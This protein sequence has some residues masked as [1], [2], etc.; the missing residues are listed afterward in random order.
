MLVVTALFFACKSKLHQENFVSK[1]L[2]VNNL[3]E[4]SFSINTKK[5]TT[6][7][8]QQGIVI[9]IDAGS[10]EAAIPN[11]TLQVKEALQL[12]DI[13]KAGL[14]TQTK[15]GILSSDGMFHIQTKE[16]SKIIKPLQIQLPTEVVD[17]NM[18]LYKGAEEDGKIV[19][20]EPKKLEPK[21][22]DEPDGKALFVK[23][24][25]SCHAIDKKLTGPALGGVETRWNKKIDL[26]NYI[27]NTSK[28]MKLIR[29]SSFPAT[30]TIP[31]AV[32][33]IKYYHNVEGNTYT[34]YDSAYQMDWGYAN[35]MYC[36]YN[37]SAMN[38][39]EGVLN[40]KDINDILDYIKK[41]TKKLGNWNDTRWLFDSCVYYLK[42]ME[43]LERLKH[44]FIVDNGEMVELKNMNPTA[45]TFNIVA[46]PKVVVK[47]YAAEYYK[48]TIDAYGWYNVDM[49]L[50]KGFPQ[51]NLSV[52]IK[53]S[54]TQKF[55]IFLVVPSLKILAEGGL[56][57]D[58]KSYGFY[59]QD[60]MI[61]LPQN[62]D[63]FVF[64]VGEENEKTFFGLE[65]FTTSTN[66]N[67]N[68]KIE[69]TS[70]EKMLRKMDRLKLN[71]FKMKIEPTKNFKEIK[72]IDSEIKTLEDKF[73]KQCGCMEYVMH[74]DA[75][76]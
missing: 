27:K 4:Q 39:F 64:A 49:L 18:Q 34:K 56:L 72:T 50:D 30:D 26:I 45:D 21:P 44:D 71:D 73:T 69:E 42:R 32:D 35:F 15:D 28:F 7:K 59:G 5:D 66:Q 40:D 43:N 63:A 36:Q 14:T 51:C 17:D 46:P 47:K 67:I 25:A 65:H 41:E 53:K 19:W 13:L 76:R 20:Q 74:Q 11:V 2:N 1:Y 12:E 6:I 57:N 8:T 31:E 23:N 75:I 60:G 61:Y 55:E 58:G 62:E 24:C 52:N 16:E 37:K 38:V 22:T 54:E 33:G 10:I 68:I 48:F 9:K 29:D 70:K 3:Q